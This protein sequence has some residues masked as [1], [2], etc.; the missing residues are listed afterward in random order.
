MIREA[1]K[2]E[3]KFILANWLRMYRFSKPMKSIPSKIYFNEYN[4]VIL[5]CLDKNMTLLAAFKD[6]PKILYGF[7]N[8]SDGKINY[9]FVKKNFRG[10]GI[11]KFL[12]NTA[13]PEESKEIIITHLPKKNKFP[14]NIKF[15]YNPFILQKELNL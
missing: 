4:K 2:K 12:F 10:L 5:N 7:I 15:I 1:T 13:F 8:Y 11:G 9:I 14:E 3:N 6:D